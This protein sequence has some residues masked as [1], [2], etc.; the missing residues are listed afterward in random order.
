MPTSLIVALGI[1]GEF[2]PQS[3]ALV[4]RAIGKISFLDCCVGK[5]GSAQ[6]D[7]ADH[8]GNICAGQTALCLQSSRTYG[9]S[10]VRF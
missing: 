7:T 6:P 10:V 2:R 8:D 5:T 1:P 9:T 3:D 4:V